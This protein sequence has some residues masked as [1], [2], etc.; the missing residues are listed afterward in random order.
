MRRLTSK[1]K[2]IVKVRDHPHTNMIS[3][4]A[5]VR[6]GGYKGMTLEMHLQL[7][8]QQLKTILC[9]Y[10]LLYQN[11]MVTANPKPAIDTHTNK[12]KQSIHNS[13]D[14]YQTT[15]EEN[16]RR[17]EEKKTNKNKSKT[18]NKMAIR[19]YISIIILD[20]NVLKT[21]NKRH[22]L[23]KWIQKQDPCICHLQETHFRSK[24]T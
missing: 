12:K 10:R 19:I 3:K 18:M 15:R 22:R 14:S 13:K 7:K 11:L 16:K 9:T 21:P 2:H 6:R 5:T 23:A 20:V 24:D 8:G 1:S 4:P 17:W